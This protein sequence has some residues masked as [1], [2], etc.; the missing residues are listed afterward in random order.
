MVPLSAR[1][2]IISDTFVQCAFPHLL[3]IAPLS[4]WRALVCMPSSRPGGCN[5]HT[6]C[7]RWYPSS[8]VSSR[9]SRDGYGR[10]LMREMP[11]QR[12]RLRW[13]FTSSRIFYGCGGSRC[14]ATLSSQGKP[15]R[16][17][18]YARGS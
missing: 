11:V 2:T 14:A 3:A 17:K 10:N 18:S 5:P 13:G 12:C 8:L 15:A 4:C 9:H 16:S 6:G 1:I 7:G